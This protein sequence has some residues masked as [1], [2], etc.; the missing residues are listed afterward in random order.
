MTVR[1]AALLAVFATLLATGLS[2]G[3]PAYYAL[4]AAA[5]A[6]FCVA[7]L[8]VLLT[9]LTARVRVQ[10]VSARVTRGENALAR[11]RVRHAGL[12]P[13]GTITVDLRTASDPQTVDVTCPPLRESQRTLALPCPHRGV[14]TVGAERL[15]ARDL[16]GLV[17][18][19]RRISGGM[20]TL[21]SAPRVPR[22]EPLELGAGDTGPEARSRS[23]EDNASPSG[24]REWRDGDELK[25]V[26]W[27]LTMRR[28]EI[29][30]RTYEETARPDTLILVDL[31]PIGA[32]RG[33][34]LAIEDAACEAAAAA[35]SAQL[36]AGYP[37]RMPLS[38]SRPME[39]QG[40]QPAD[41]LRFVEALTTA[42]FDCAYTY[43]QL[44]AVEMRRVQRTGGAVLITPRL[45]MRV[46]DTA[47]RM[48]AGG[49]RVR[50]CWI[51]EPRASEG[52]DVV[53]RLAIAGVEVQKIDPTRPISDDTAFPTGALFPQ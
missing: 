29:I 7:I 45:T 20:F 15:T 23:A 11:I 21:Q 19:S 18:L 53:A 22:A 24:I 4:A 32:L 2:T 39:V 10:A 36:R 1:A 48:R 25:K 27:K 28:R 12:L 49:L 52:A 34:M 8:S 6:L 16:F 37:V 26:H 41:I 40:Q 9:I 14:Y 3:V 33:R 47:M 42:P 46:A 17:H 50:L 35:A 51:T 44:L 31:A 13:V 30:V 38:C 5:G 43:D